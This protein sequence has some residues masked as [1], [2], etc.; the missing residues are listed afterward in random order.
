MEVNNSPFYLNNK[1][2][3]IMEEKIPF[4]ITIKNKIFGDKFNTRCLRTV[5]TIPAGLLEEILIDQF[6][7][8]YRI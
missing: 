5:K 2:K 6:L 1:L 8:V 7:N 3:N 4:M